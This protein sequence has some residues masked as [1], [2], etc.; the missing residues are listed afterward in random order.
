[1]EHLAG[2]VCHGLCAPARTSKQTLHH[3][4]RSQQ[5]PNP[6]AGFSTFCLCTQPSAMAAFAVSSAGL[7]PP[8]APPL[9]SCPARPAPP[10]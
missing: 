6:E 7:R 2:C 3:L 4:R 5:S 8:A 9:P 1:M 10:T